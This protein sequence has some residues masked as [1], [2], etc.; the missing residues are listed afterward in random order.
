ML[1]SFRP[2]NIAATGDDPMLIRLL[3]TLC[4]LMFVLCIPGYGVTIYAI[5]S[6]N[7]LVTFDSASPSVLTSAKILKLPSLSNYDSNRPSERIV[8]LAF[9]T[10][11][12]PATTRLWGL[13]NYGNI[14]AVNI[15]TAEISPPTIKGIN[16]NGTAFGFGFD[17]ASTV[18]MLLV[19]NMEQNLRLK[20]NT[21]EVFTQT[22]LSYMG[23]TPTDP[24]IVTL[25]YDNN[26]SG[27]SLRTPYMIDSAADTL[28][29]LLF[30]FSDGVLKTV[31]PLGVNASE[32]TGLT[33]YTTGT[34]GSPVNTAFAAIA[35]PGDS[36]SKLYT[37]DLLTGAATLV[38]PIGK[39]EQGTYITAI[40]VISG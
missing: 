28:V 4:I 7:H 36:A 30:P 19:S 33:I 25:A 21:G 5:D 37:I 31:G 14:V 15:G 17:P 9:R 13:T 38:G 34:V 24:N 23:G 3:L 16:L 12:G 22:P 11:D 26:L 35:S 2:F 8:S 10:A 18:N 40:A 27:G 20:F 1:A 29:M 32:V 6:Q 39:Y